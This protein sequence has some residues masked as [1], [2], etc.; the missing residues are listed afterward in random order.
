MGTWV[1]CAD[2]G[3]VL[4]GIG[5]MP[6]PHVISSWCNVRDSRNTRTSVVEWSSAEWSPS[7]KI[8]SNIRIS[9]ELVFPGYSR[10]LYDAHSQC[11]GLAMF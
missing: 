4:S 6:L 10:F 3:Y 1:G 8:Y 5:H 2:L 9:R 11:H 7:A